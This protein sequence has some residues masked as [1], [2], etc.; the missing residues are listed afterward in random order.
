MKT[1]MLAVV[2]V[3]ALA[4]CS[5][6]PASSTCDESCIGP[7]G[8]VGP[9]GPP[10]IQ[11]PTGPQGPQGA[12][13]PQGATGPQGPRGEVGPAGPQ[14]AA[15]ATGAQGPQG[16]QG[17]AGAPGA[18][19]ATGATGAQGPQG[20]Q[21]PQGATGPQGPAGVPG[22]STRVLSVNGESIGFSIPWRGMT[23]G[24]D[25]ALYAFQDNPEANF[26]QGWIIPLDP[27]GYIHFSGQ[28]C[29]GTP[30]YAS[31]PGYSNLR[32]SNYLFHVKGR[33]E[34]YKKAVNQT[35]GMTSTSKRHPSTGSCSAGDGGGTYIILED[36]GF[37]MQVN[38]TLPWQM[39][40]E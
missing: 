30:M 34:L 1:M 21:G 35:G 14:G 2:S 32:Y 23:G 40:V 7:Q 18:A 3:L 38:T 27:L 31:D 29:T 12:A 10:G 15:G 36:T 6:D 9:Q 39:V 16:I 24:M 28:N 26:P 4:A 11:G 37:R 25:V 5:Q 17:P 19:G 22:M 13:G 8:E 33:S 20:V